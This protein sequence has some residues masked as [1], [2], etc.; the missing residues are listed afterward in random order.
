MD[1][2]TRGLTMT[3][4]LTRIELDDAIELATNGT[5]HADDVLSVCVMEVDRSDSRDGFPYWNV[6]VN[7]PIGYRTGE[8]ITVKRF[9]H[10]AKAA[11]QSYA[12]DVAD[13]LGVDAV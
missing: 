5:R 12:W 11:A 13:A 4:I 9:N 7:V 1:T 2:I 3:D 6:C 10:N 8:Q